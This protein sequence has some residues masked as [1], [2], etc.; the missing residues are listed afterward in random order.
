VLAKGIPIRIDGAPTGSESQGMTPTDFQ[1]SLDSYLAAFGYSTANGNVQASIVGSGAQGKAWINKFY[2]STKP[3]THAAFGGYLVTRL[4]GFTQGDA[5]ALVDRS[6]ASDGNPPSGSF[7]FD[8]DSN[9]GIADPT[10]FPPATPSTNVT[11]E[12]SFGDGN[13]DLE[14]AAQTLQASGIPTDLAITTT[15]VGN[16]SNLGGYFSWGSNDSD[17][18]NVAYESLSFASGS[19]SNT[20]V[21]TSMRTFFRQ[22]VGFNSVLLTGMTSLRARVANGNSDNHSYIFQVRLDNPSGQVIGTCTVP[23]TGDS[24]KWTTTT[25]NLT[26]NLT[27]VHNVYLIFVPNGFGGGLYNLEWIAFAGTPSLIEAASF[28]D[29]ADGPLLE[30][31]SEGSQDLGFITNG[32]FAKYSSI[33]LAKMTSFNA[34]VA[35]AGSGGN[36]EIHLDNPGGTR[37]GTCSVPV[38]GG[39]QTYVSTSCNLKGAGGI[40]DVYLVFTGGGGFLFNVEWFR[41]VGGTS[42]IEA[43]SFNSLSG[44]AFLEN[45]SEG[46]MDLTNIFDGQSEMGDLIANGLTG[47]EGYVNEP[48]L[49]GIVGITFNVQHYTAGYTLAESFLSGNP[50]L[51]WEGTV[52]GD[53]LAAPY[54]GATAST[55]HRKPGQGH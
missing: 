8:V 3:F 34:R 40:H 43:A 33:N 15:F 11:A 22:Y 35:S 44:G 4:D 53:P 20:Y 27:G 2:N 25:C 29:V 46:A 24:Q 5:M 55:T 50:Y 47:A 30:Q 9:F 36:I 16:Q 54:F 17:Y 49:D 7:L 51:G 38:T 13:A 12:E 48:T 18:N 39:W 42:I 37:I 19:I 21:S 10:Q 23:E 41:F 52:V 26:P 32:T 45:S 14:H 31:D 6:L 1:P 28:N